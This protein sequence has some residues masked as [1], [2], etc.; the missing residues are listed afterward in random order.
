MASTSRSDLME[1]FRVRVHCFVVCSIVFS[2]N[3]RRPCKG[4]VPPP[5]SK[6]NL[7]I[8]GQERH[9]PKLHEDNFQTKLFTCVTSAFM[10]YKAT[11]VKTLSC[12][13]SY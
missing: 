10:C 8:T 7:R 2:A 11:S 12:N 6:I 4:C 5:W 9:K 13:T 1:F 3:Q